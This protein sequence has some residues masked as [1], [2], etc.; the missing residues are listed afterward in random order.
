M[1]VPLENVILNLKSVGI[2]SV[3]DFPYPTRPQS[4]N[5]LVALQNLIIL[6]AI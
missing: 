1:S 2:K 5:L 3:V 6:K 4:K